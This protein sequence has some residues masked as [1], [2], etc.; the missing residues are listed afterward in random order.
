MANLVRERKHGDVT[1]FNVTGI[2]IQRMFAS[3]VA[4]LCAFGKQKRDPNS[5]T[6]S[7][8]QVWKRLASAGRSHHRIS[9][10][11][12][13]CI[14]A[15][16]RLVL[17][18]LRGLKE[19]YPTVHLKAFTMVEDRL[20]RAPRKNQHSRSAGTPA[21]RRHGFL[22]GR[23]WRRF[24]VSACA[25]SFCDHKLTGDEWL[26]AA[27]TAH[28]LGCIPT[29]RCFTATSRMK[30]TARS[31]HPLRALQDDTN[32]FVTFIPPG[33]PPGQHRAFSHLENNRLR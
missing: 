18:M 9:Y 30:K 14:R 25:A 5:Y 16:P 28:E 1:Y 33:F 7:L 13:A 21:C 2:S 24:S 22:P 8:E 6:M 3:P 11:S 15:E 26:E 20:L 19:R 4:G 32:G 31:P 23:R 12:V 17:Q 27:R 29:A 10:S